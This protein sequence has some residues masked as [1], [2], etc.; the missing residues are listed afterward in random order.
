MIVQVR[1]SAIFSDRHPE[2]R[3]GDP[4]RLRLPDDATVANLLQTLKLP[5]AGRVAVVSKG[6][7]MDP[8]R[9]MKNGDCVTILPVV[10]GG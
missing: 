3:T 4:L 10:E 5:K 8:N 2:T 7:V 6:R 9:P 1:L